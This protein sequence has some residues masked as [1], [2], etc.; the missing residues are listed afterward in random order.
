METVGKILKKRREEKNISL[1]FISNELNIS[2]DLLDKIENDKIAKSADIVFHV[3][4]IR[5]YANF[6]DL[7]SDDIIL[8]FKILFQQTCCF[9]QFAIP[10]LPI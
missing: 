2:R 3:G 1:S 6:I 10:F 7:N 8:L 5:T 9:N 4:H